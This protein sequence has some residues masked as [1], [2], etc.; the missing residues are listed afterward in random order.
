[1]KNIIFILLSVLVIVSCEQKKESGINTGEYIG[2]NFKIYEE[3]TTEQIIKQ[4]KYIALETDS[5]CLL[6]NPQQVKFINDTLFILDKENLFTF[7]NQGKFVAKIG[8]KGRAPTEYIHLTS[9]FVDSKNSYAA[10][11]DNIN[12]KILKYSFKG[13]FIESISIKQNIMQFV[14]QIDFL[15]KENAIICSYSLPFEPLSMPN[16]LSTIS[17]KDYSI[18]SHIP[19]KIKSTGRALVNFSSH[20]ITLSQDSSLIPLCIEPFSNKIMGYVNDKFIVKYT[21]KT[22]DPIVSVQT[23][24]SLTNSFN[25][26]FDVFENIQKNKKSVGIKNIYETTNYIL[27]S[28][29]GKDKTYSALYDKKKK[30]GAFY[31]NYYSN[32]TSSY[33]DVLL[34]LSGSS[35]TYKDQF[36]LI[37]NQ[38]LQDIRNT[39]IQE[40]KNQDF[41]SIL[42]ATSEDDNPIIAFIELK[43]SIPF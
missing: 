18:I 1:M 9:F 10:I 27:L 15:T 22:I 38:P 43:D 4:I 17:L 36:I 37:L 32:I 30:K 34:G 24:E 23:L 14:N 13:E 12:S 31:L 29:G 25:N 21:V 7:T 26:Y 33:H 2:Q 39:F 8:N 6:Q 3:I 28:I 5:L 35:S 41:V 16:S 40:S 20:P 19:Y 42:K 11:F